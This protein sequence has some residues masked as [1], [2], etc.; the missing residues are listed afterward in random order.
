MTGTDD[1]RK[2][3]KPNPPARAYERESS[4]GS[5]HRSLVGKPAVHDGGPPAPLLADMARQSM[6]AFAGL[7]TARYRGTSLTSATGGHQ[8]HERGKEFDVDYSFQRYELKKRHSCVL[9][10]DV[11]IQGLCVSRHS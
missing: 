5:K 9:T 7:N 8:Y 4:S 11:F 2:R 3:T 10:S 6:L 1:E